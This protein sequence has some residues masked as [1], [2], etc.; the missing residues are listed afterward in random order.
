MSNTFRRS[1]Y[2]IRIKQRDNHIQSSGDTHDVLEQIIVQPSAVI[3]SND[4]LYMI[5]LLLLAICYV[6][7][8]VI[9]LQEK[10][11]RFDDNDQY[12]YFD[13][14]EREIPRLLWFRKGYVLH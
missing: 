6:Y 7:Y 12:Y 4:Y 5:Y 11:P 1:P 14:Y 13:N 2:S 10:T 8:I 9:I 3:N